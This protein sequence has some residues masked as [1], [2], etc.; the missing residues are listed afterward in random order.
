QSLMQKLSDL[1]DTNSINKKVELQT[2]ALNEHLKNT[3]YAIDVQNLSGEELKKYLIKEAA[4]D[5]SLAEY[6]EQLNQLEVELIGEATIDAAQNANAKMQMLDRLVENRK[7][8]QALRLQNDL[9]Q[10][11]PEK[12]SDLLNRLYHQEPEF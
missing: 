10:N 5:S 4:Q 3:V 6:L 8:E 11:A 12:H 9:I 1:L 7:I 2:K